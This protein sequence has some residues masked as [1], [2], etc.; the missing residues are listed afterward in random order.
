MTYLLEADLFYMKKATSWG[1]E[2]VVG[3]YQKELIL[4]NILR[5]LEIKKGET[6]LDLACGP[7][8]FAR[9]FFKK[10]GEVV[11][12]DISKDLITLAK[13]SSPANI[14]YHIGSAENLSFLKEK[15][16][17]KAV[18][19]LAIQNISDINAVFQE[20]ARVLRPGGKLFMAMNHPAFRVPKESSWDWDET[21]QAQYR[22]ID[23][24]MSD[25]SVK[26]QMHPSTGSWRALGD[27]T[28]TFHRPLQGYFKAMRRAG[29]CVD[30]LEEWI[31]QKHSQSGPRA[32][33]EDIARKEI[34]LF[35]I[36]GAIKSV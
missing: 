9:E 24:Y 18:I 15:S 8:F 19:I 11:G 27:Y 16:A 5:L 35:M 32:K 23:K 28:T 3:V 17:D 34:P 10:G 7:G 2:A 36:L 29:F 31:S 22:R 30:T 21:A 13:K 14:E 25:F 1:K 6:I 20:C 33:A 4:P 12:V 26:I